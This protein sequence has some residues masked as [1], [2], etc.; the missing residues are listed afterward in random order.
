MWMKRSHQRR[1][2]FVWDLC[3]FPK[4]RRGGFASPS[5]LFLKQASATIAAIEAMAMKARFVFFGWQSLVVCRIL[6]ADSV[7]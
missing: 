4:R 3:R 6:L 2:N 1:K 7:L 5:F